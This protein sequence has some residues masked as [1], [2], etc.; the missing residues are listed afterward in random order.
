MALRA[1]AGL[2][3]PDQ[4]HLAPS[5]IQPVLHLEYQL[6]LRSGALVLPWLVV[7]VC[8][9]LSPVWTTDRHCSLVSSHASYSCWPGSLDSPGASPHCV[10]A[11]WPCSG[12]VQWWQLLRAQPVLQSPLD[13]AHPP[14]W[15]CPA[16]DAP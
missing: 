6:E 12:S 2:K 7:W 8:L 13:P 14:S 1:A 9:S 5:S 16:S 4:P 10:W 15:S 3:Y 11:C